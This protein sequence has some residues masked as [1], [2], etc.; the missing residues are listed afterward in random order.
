MG[1]YHQ[2]VLLENRIHDCNESKISLAVA[3]DETLPYNNILNYRCF[4]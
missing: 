3:I 1:T 2:I 4:S